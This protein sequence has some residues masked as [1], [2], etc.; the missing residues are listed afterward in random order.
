MLVDDDR[1]VRRSLKRMLERQGYRVV[2]AGG[3][4]EALNLA[5]RQPVDAVVTDMW[6]DD[7]NGLGLVRQLAARGLRRPTV[8]LTAMPEDQHEAQ[9]RELGV[10]AILQKPITLEDLCAALEATLAAK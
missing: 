1:L 10:A 4:A 2:E 9:A 8:L 6:M 3:V 7:G 5:E